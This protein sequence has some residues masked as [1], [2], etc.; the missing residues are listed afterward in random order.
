MGTDASPSVY[1]ASQSL[2]MPKEE[3]MLLEIH[4]PS[5]SKGRVSTSGGRGQHLSH[6]LCHGLN[7]SH[8]DVNASR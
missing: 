3:K 4:A 8:I 6:G 7:R 1:E 2:Q 5:L